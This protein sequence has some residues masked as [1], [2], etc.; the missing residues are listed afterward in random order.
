MATFAV[1]QQTDRAVL[2]QQLALEFAS[3]D[4]PGSR[5]ET[6]RGRRRA[7]GSGHRR[8]ETSG[9]SPAVGCV[10][11]T[12]RGGERSR[13]AHPVVFV[14]DKHGRPLQP[15]SAAR[16]RKLLKQGRAA[17]HRH[18]PFVIRLRD[19]TVAKSSVDGVELGID[20]GSKRTGL[21]VFTPAGGETGVIRRGLYA[22]ELNH[23][24]S[25]IRES[26]ARR[27]A[28]RR[29]RRSRNLRYRAPR[30]N[31]R[32][33]PDGW[34]A[35]SLRHRVV[36]TMAWVGRLARWA[37]IKAVHV[38][39]VAFDTHVLSK[40]RDLSREEYQHGTL[41]GTEVREYL[42]AKWSR[43][44]AYCGAT[45]VPL[46]IDHIRPKSK[47][48]SDRISNL[49]LAC[50]PCNESKSSQAIE[51]FLSG[52]P[53]VLA[54]IITQAKA[55]LSCAAAVNATRSA[56]TRALGISFAVVRTASGGRPTGTARVTA[57]PRLT[58]STLCVWA[59]STPYG[60]TPAPSWLWRRP[61]AGRTPVPVPTDTAFLACDCHGRNT[62]S[63][64]LPA[65][66]RAPLFPPVFAQVR[67]SGDSPSGPP[68]AST[69][70]PGTVSSRGSTTGISA[71]S[72]GRTALT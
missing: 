11:P 62:S 41:H 42:L 67:T 46:N 4:T 71:S 69:S 58:A 60:S 68:V 65:T 49:T 56:L 21:A 26:L 19:R 54:K 24:G 7:P 35:P 14:L 53:N 10:T 15:T 63:D 12:P 34:L 40:G 33:R 44:C 37:P 9:G 28:Y 25:R 8:G 43:A 2:P 30:F 55:P 66:T 45:G 16:A 5:D 13:E 20:P 51:E 3:A 36:T 22:I 1:G 59:L 50:I 38:E 31:N 27:T 52:R 48:G 57:C 70:A 47:G 64:S 23:R 72:N 18:A 17:V 6:G 29:R 39:R 61:G 32:T